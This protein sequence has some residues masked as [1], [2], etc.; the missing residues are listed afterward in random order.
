MGGVVALVGLRLRVHNPSQ[1][2][3]A[4]TATALSTLLRLQLSD[5]GNPTAQAE[6]DALYAWQLPRGSQNPKLVVLSPDG[7]QHKLDLGPLPPP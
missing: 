4:F 6:Q 1:Q 5:G 7:S 3:I 2:R